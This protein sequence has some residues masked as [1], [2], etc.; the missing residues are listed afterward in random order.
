MDKY[1]AVRQLTPADKVVV[2]LVYRI[3]RDADVRWALGDGTEAFRLLCVAYADLVG[4][5]AQLVESDLKRMQADGLSAAEKLER[6]KQC[7]R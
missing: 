4:V 7:L 1:K 3:A 5:D 2:H 6:V